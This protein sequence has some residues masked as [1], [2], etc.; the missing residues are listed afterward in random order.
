[1][2]S[3]APPPVDMPHLVGAHDVDLAHHLS[4]GP[5]RLTLCG[6]RNAEAPRTGAAAAAMCATCLRLALQEGY[7]VA[8]LKDNA[9][10]NL[11]RLQVDG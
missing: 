4:V 11:T 7:T 3:S 8:L 10:M 5:C 6:V 1:M 9:Y 2:Q